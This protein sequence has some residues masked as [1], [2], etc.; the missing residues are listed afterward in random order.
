MNIYLGIDEEPDRSF[1]RELSSL[2]NKYGYDT[3][4][5]IRDWVLAQ[6]VRANLLVL[7]R[8]LE[9]ETS[10]KKIDFMHMELNR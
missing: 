10:N 5:N 2:L 7:S 3:K 8:T 1:V 9:L 6:Y 4:T